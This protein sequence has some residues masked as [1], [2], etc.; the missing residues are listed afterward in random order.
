M[1]PKEKIP[2]KQII[3]MHGNGHYNTFIITTTKMSLRNNHMYKTVV[4][5]FSKLWNIKSIE[6]YSAIK[7][8]IMKTLEKQEK[9]LYYDIKGENGIKI[10]CTLGLQLF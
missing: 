10:L 3:Y 9:C 4:K 6:Y 2:Q 5:L 7:I 8:I 1:C